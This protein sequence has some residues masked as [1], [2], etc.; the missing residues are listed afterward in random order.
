MIRVD[1]WVE[2]KVLDL[3]G[4]EQIVIN[5]SAQNTQDFSKIYTD[6]SQTFTVPCSKNNNE[7]FEHY[8]NNDVDGI[9]DSQ[10]RRQS[11]I[12]ID[13]IP[14]RTGK[15]QI[16][17]SQIKNGQAESYTVTFFGDLV[18]LKDTIG[19]DKLKDLNYN[20]INHSITASEVL[21]RITGV[22]QDSIGYPLI[23]SDRLWTYNDGGANDINT[24]AGS[25]SYD[26]L[27]PSLKVWKIIDL[28]ELKYGI[29]LTGAFLNTER[30]LALALWYKTKLET[31]IVSQPYDLYNDGD[32][33]FPNGYIFGDIDFQWRDPSTFGTSNVISEITHSVRVQINTTSTAD[34]F[35]DV[36]QDDTLTTSLIKAG[37][38]N[39]L[40]YIMTNGAN[41]TTLDR[42]F[43]FKIRSKV[44]A[45]FT[46]SLIYEVKYKETDPTTGEYSNHTV[47]YTNAFETVNVILKTDLAN[48]APDIKVMDFLKGVS[49]MFNFTIQG[50][51]EDS[52]KWIPLDDF[53]ESG[54]EYNI[55]DF[56]DISSITVERPKLFKE[57]NFKYQESKSLLNS[58]FYD[59]FQRRYSDLSA[60]FPYDGGKF[61][62]TL[63]FETILHTKYSGQNLQVGFCI[64]DQQK[65][66][67]PK[68]VMLYENTQI[69][70]VG[71]YFE[72]TYHSGSYMP[73]GQDM[74]DQ[75]GNYN[76]NF[77]LELS[78][79]TGNAEP[80][81]LYSM[82]Y[83]EYLSNLY[84]RKT[85]KVQVKTNLSQKLL[86]NIKLNDKLI[87][88]DK[89][90][91]IDKMT[92]S[93]TKKE[94]KLDLI[95]WWPLDYST[96][97]S[98]YFNRYGG[99]VVIGVE[100][101]DNTISLATPT[102]GSFSATSGSGSFNTTFTCTPNTTGLSKSQNILATVT[103]IH[104]T[105]NTF[106]INV[107]QTP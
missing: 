42:N 81:T 41:Y 48:N 58:Q 46:G 68:P 86:T 40:S 96:N 93:L 61:D 106:L 83:D 107:N 69:S 17:K 92:T 11:K 53:Y 12:E 95:S 90:Y 98:Y 91:I 73:F 39:N 2:D 57:I 32:V 78:S 33:T 43:S 8:Y 19:E 101:G 60:S 1:V 30:F 63:P 22:T 37:G 25:I 105:T 24:G 74:S 104:G 102:F 4:D 88:K 55:T 52:Y 34:W 66:Y 45:A 99:S 76:I 49:N 77:N 21:N 10:I 79:Y 64:D 15:I 38:G 85:R 16:E 54:N 65:A 36:Y 29:S 27:F 47:T 71:F 80:N 56:V 87:I 72:G 94:V 82:F 20:S 35:L 44:A 3:F 70:T 59:L 62:L 23:S 6:F 84:D 50:N 5:S 28:I 51:G 9:L 89:R 100:L 97:K 7:I 103:D 31:N 18:S 75:S 13:W 67:I 26:E 14:F